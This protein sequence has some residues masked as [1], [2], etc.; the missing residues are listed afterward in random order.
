MRTLFLALV[1][2]GCG[3]PPTPEAPIGAVEKNGPVIATVDGETV[4][5]EMVTTAARHVPKEQFEELEKDPERFEQVFEPLMLGQAL[6]KRA[7]DA[8]LATER[9]ELELALRLAERDFLVNEYLAREAE[10]GLRWPQAMR[11]AL[12]LRNGVAGARRWRRHWSD[13]TLRDRPPRAV[14]AMY[15]PEEPG[16]A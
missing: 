8:G 14:A 3:A 2:A 10:K 5:R 6:Y 13:H 4:T 12:G 7:V 1:L 16:T 11:H 9:K 15:A